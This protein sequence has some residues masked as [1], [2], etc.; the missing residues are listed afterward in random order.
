MPSPFAVRSFRFQWPADLL[1]SWAFEME[2]LILGWYVLSATG[3]VTQLAAV[4][5]LAWL[6]SLFSPFF[7][8]AGD[9]IGHRAVL[10]I[11]R[12]VYALLAAVMTALTLSD[13][14]QPWHVFA[15][16]ATAGLLRPSDMVMRSVLV[17]QTM[18]SEMLMGALGLSRTTSDTARVAGA[19]AGAGG[20]ALIGMGAA[21]V[22]V[23]V[24]YILAV[25]LTL[26]VAGPA[27]RVA[28]AHPWADLKDGFRYAWHKPD[29]VATFAM[30]FLVNLLAYPFV[31]GL[32]PY[33]AKDV[34][35]AG[36]VVLGY[37]AASYWSGAL[38]GSIFVGAGR[39]PRGAARVMLWSAGLWFAA[40]LLFGQATTLWIGL[41]LLFIAGFMQS[42]CLTPLAAIML[43]SSDEAMRGRVM[44]VRMLAIWGLP[45]GLVAAGPLIEWIGYAATNFI[46]TALGLAATVAI[47]W[48]WREALWHR[49]AAANVA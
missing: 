18:R 36:Q 2:A 12:S 19:L 48:R 23:T 21:Y 29:L 40:T 17:G 9:R 33:V 13:A 27:A 14:L 32:L 3:S 41:P 49:S 31:L 26:G 42:F 28:S 24:L 45:L 8:L 43:R 37:L 35:G 1:T 47:A 4:A 11:T 15:I 38:A 20:V 30:A 7:G 34:Y 22:I 6:G 44:G 39:L 5:A 16:A 25:L 46:Y 10:C